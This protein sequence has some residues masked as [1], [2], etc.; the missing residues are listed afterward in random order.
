MGSYGNLA[1]YMSSLSTRFTERAQITRMEEF[2]KTHEAILGTA[3]NTLNAAVNSANYEQYW[4]SLHY[5]TIEQVL[6][7]KLDDGAAATFFSLT[8]IVFG[9]IASRLLA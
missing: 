9:V 5:A 2:A 4:S 7:E 8:L 1:S 3:V 6:Q